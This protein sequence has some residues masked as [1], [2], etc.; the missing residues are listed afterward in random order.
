[1]GIGK[2]IYSR[3][4]VAGREELGAVVDPTLTE[5][6]A[7]GILFRIGRNFLVGSLWR[8]RMGSSAGRLFVGRRVSILSP[9][10]IHVGRDVKI[11]DLAEVQGLSSGGIHLGDGVTI[12]RGASIRPS[13]Y[14]GGPLGEGLKVGSR[15]SIGAYCWIGASGFVDIGSNVMLGPRV[16]IIPENHNFEETGTPIRDQGVERMPVVIGDDCW[17]GANATILAGVTI[18]AGSIVAAG[19]VVT[20]DVESGSIVGGVPARLLRKRGEGI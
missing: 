9:R 4:L 15:S 14:Y 16:V 13:S 5:F 2:V 17:I 19:A 8:I 3:L 6:D 12:G 1:M 7:W 20:R 11:E 18:G 10:S